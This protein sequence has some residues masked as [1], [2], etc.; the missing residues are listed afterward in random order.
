MLSAS[1]Q[2]RSL[3]FGLNVTDLFNSRKIENLGLSGSGPSANTAHGLNQTADQLYY[4][5]GRQVTGDITV[6]F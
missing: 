6:K 1:Y 5:P 3:R 4:Q 2:W